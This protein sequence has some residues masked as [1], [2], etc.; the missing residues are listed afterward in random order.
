M[1]LSTTSWYS[2]CLAAVVEIGEPFQG[3]V[4][5]FEVF[6]LVDLVEL[7]ERVPGDFQSG[8]GS[9]E[10]VQ[11]RLVGVCAIIGAAQ[12]G[13]PG[14]EQVGLIR[15]GC[16]VGWAALE[17]AACQGEP[18]CEPADNVE[19]VQ[20]MAG[21]AQILR[22]GRPIGAGTV[23][24]DDLHSSTPLRSLVSEEPGQRSFITSGDHRQQLAGVAGGDYGHIAVTAAYRRL[25]D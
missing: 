10:P 7:L 2:R 5:G 1:I 17:L 12:E 8:M 23:G 16:A 20:H 13:E 22:D 18:L 24:H 14:S 25:V 15:G 21:V 4:G 6:G 3:L 11:M 19:P 9:K